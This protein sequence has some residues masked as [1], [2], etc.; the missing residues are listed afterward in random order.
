LWS[1]N[2]QEL[3]YLSLLEGVVMGVRVQAGS[4]WSSSTPERVLQGQYFYSVVGN[5]R[6]FDIAPDG[7]R[8]LMIKEAGADDAAA[9]Q[10]R[11]VFVQHWVEELNRLVPTN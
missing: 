11:L 3:F 2:G 9:P 1:R 8:F 6:T 10:N 7:R 5:G 4:S